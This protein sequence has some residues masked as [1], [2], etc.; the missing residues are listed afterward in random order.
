[1][2]NFGTTTFPDELLDLGPQT[3]PIEP[4]MKETY[5]LSLRNLI[6]RLNPESRS[7]YKCLTDGEGVV[8]LYYC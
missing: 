2:K 7:Q 6:P 8:T 4:G 5:R 3:T 1:M